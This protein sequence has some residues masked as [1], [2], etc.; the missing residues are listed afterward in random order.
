FFFSSRRRHTRSKRDWSSDVC[1][2][3]LA[4]EGDPLELDVG[5]THAR[6]QK[7]QQRDQT[8][9]G[10]HPAPPHPAQRQTRTVLTHS[11]PPLS[12]PAYG[13]QNSSIA[14]RKRSWASSCAQCPQFGT[15]INS[16]RGIASA[17]RTDPCG[18]T[19]GSSAPWKN[20]V[21]TVIP[22]TRPVRSLVIP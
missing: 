3:D 20:R 18:S 21:G 2:S 9:R 14:G 7:A 6:P 8:C 13:E 22:A 1:S 5:M 10:E 11:L 19:S 17:A 16:A 15:M 12:R 4:E